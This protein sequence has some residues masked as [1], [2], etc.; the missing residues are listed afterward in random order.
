MYECRRCRRYLTVY[1]CHEKYGK[2]VRVTPNQV[3][4]ADPDAIPIVYEHG[5]GYLK[6]DFYDAFVSIHRGL[7]NTRD[8]A[9]HTRKRKTVSH[10]FSAKSI[11]QFEQYI[12]SN[13]EQLAAQWDRLSNEANGG[14][15]QM[16]A[17]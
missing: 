16:E 8:R 2:L 6:P 12:H 4:I 14:Y 17:V 7:C 13:L 15:S 10:T 1:K 3:S 9:E 5:T 11:G